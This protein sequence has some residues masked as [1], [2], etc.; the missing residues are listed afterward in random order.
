MKKIQTTSDPAAQDSESA[1]RT[2]E[3]TPGRDYLSR[4]RRRLSQLAGRRG[5]EQLLM[6]GLA[7]LAILTGLATYVAGSANSPNEA[8]N[9]LLLPLLYTIMVM[10]LVFSAVVARRL[11]EVWVQRRRGLAG[12]RLHIRLVGL[13]SIVAVIP[14][15]IVAMFAYAF[16]NIGMESW[17][18]DKV[19]TALAES[20][21]V[22]QAYLVEHQ[23][24]IRADALAVAADF[25]RNG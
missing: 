3:A 8:D 25:N 1:F 2:A 20:R 15:I 10:A 13:F 24:S 16:L 22:A 14:T 9:G 19:R 7:P 4:L 17:F 11:A 21:A 5:I 18:S 12:S 6:I 23:Q